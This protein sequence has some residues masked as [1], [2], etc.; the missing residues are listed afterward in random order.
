MKV[1][2]L[3]SEYPPIIGGGGRYTQNLVKGLSN[4]G[5]EVVLLTS[6]A[7]D[8]VEKNNDFLTIKRFKVFDDLY[9]GRGDMIEGINILIQQIKSELPDIIHTEH[10]LETLLGQVSNINF[11]LPHFVT[12]HKTPAYDKAEKLVIN[13]KWSLYDFV[14]MNTELRYTEPSNVFKNALLQSG[15][16]PKT[17]EVIYPGIDNKVFNSKE[18]EKKVTE[19]KKK[20]ELNNDDFIVLIPC[21]IRKR[22]GLEFVLKSLSQLKLENKN[23][24]IIVTGLPL[25]EKEKVL[26]T[27]LE[28]LVKPAQIVSHDTFSDQEMPVLYHLADITVLGSEAEGLG[29]SLLEAM[30]CGCPVVGT[31]V[32][33]I[34]EVIE[35]KYNGRLCRYGDTEDLLEAVLEI[36]NNEKLRDKYITNA[37][38]VLESKFNLEKQAQK[39]TELYQKSIG[40]IRQ[41][42]GG[43]LYRFKDKK[44]EI[45]LAKQPDYGYVLPKGTKEKGE[46]WLETAIREIAEETGYTV[47]IPNYSLGLIHWSFERDDGSTV[48]KECM[49]YGF[50]L[51]SKDVAGTQKLE[52][53]EKVEIG[54]WVSYNKAIKVM[55]HKTEI[56]AVEKLYKWIF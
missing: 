27:K 44:L 48:N 1:L 32:M 11:G 37:F 12:H 8:S 26:Y 55:A 18:P 3:H 33:G 41:S 21:L 4:L 23:I 50:E 46:T 13:G 2:F 29:I 34:N 19:M 47:N 14:N 5:I 38:S 52:V 20:L 31:N 7:S 39:H 28:S 30:A 35:D 25:S 16:D 42:S 10:S 6:G 43:V 53:G 40:L 24:K 49:F 36:A 51:G 9:Y 22:K 45:Y 54:E 56:D 17:I 15:S